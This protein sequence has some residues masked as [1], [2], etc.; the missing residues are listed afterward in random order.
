MARV[1]KAKPSI[2]VIVLSAAGEK[3][4]RQIS[5]LLP[6]AVLHGRAGRVGKADLYFADAA[7]HVRALFKSATPV[8][9]V[10]AAGI[11][12]R[13]V[14]PLLK[15]KIEEPPL[16]AVS[17]DGKSVVPLLGGH[18]GAN[19]LA[20][21]IARG[22]KAHAAVTTAG[23]AMLGIAL[24]DP[25]EGWRVANPEAAKS[26]AA[27]LLA[28]KPVALEID[29]GLAA[30][31]IDTLRKAIGKKKGRVTGAI[32]VTANT[33]IK[34]KALVLHPPVLAIGVGCERGAEPKEV[35]ALVKRTLAKAKLAPDAVACVT[36]LDLKA[37]EPAVQAV[38]DLLGVPSRFFFPAELEEQT[39]RLANPSEVVFQATG[40]HGVAEGAALAA[41][42]R[43]GT[44][45]VP[46]MKSEHAT[47]AIA[48]S[49][50]PLDAAKIGRPRGWLRI[51]GIGPGDA[52]W[53]T[54]EASRVIAEAT[55]LVGYKLYIDLLGDAARGKVHH[56]SA[57]GAEERRVRLALDLAAQGRAV[58]L[59]CSGDAGVYGL[60]TLALE[61]MER[62][63]R[64]EWNRLDLTVV[65]GLSALLAAAARAGAPLGHDFCTISLSDLL[66]PWPEIERRLKAA[67]AADFV[68][69]LY[70]PASE[71]R[72]DQ[73]VTARA[74]L[75]ADRLPSTPVVIA[76]NLG[77]PG[78]EVTITT[79]AGFD[80]A[81]VD[82]LTLVLIGNSTTRLAA[83]GGR[84]WV[85]TPRGYANKAS[86]P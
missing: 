82:M 41:V 38:A 21:Q 73:L 71:R 55:D 59:V 26:V 11:L 49:P 32:R 37:D 6:G 56:D 23:D 48:W 70:N 9:G 75:M 15:N 69:A 63:A 17:S 5:R 19:R 43:K 57:L 4:A 20:A 27:A 68:V 78:E 18:H 51:V 74:I 54:P 42:G 72:R 64:P 13:A 33:A 36:S 31:W 84:T 58:A 46:K 44:L 77:R 45:I 76:R 65:P 16:I 79:L 14:A 81:R 66:T 28:G 40:T 85:H 67:A 22:L 30:P 61:L 7:A 25:P 3:T 10:C 53:R 62:E 52:E 60:A 86:T 29:D 34:G 8:I 24:D 50:V 12:I 2:V 83:H 80:P 47:C 39:P 35:I 1:T